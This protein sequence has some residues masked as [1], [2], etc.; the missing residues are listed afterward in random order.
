[1]NSIQIPTTTLTILS[2]QL[3]GQLHFDPL[4]RVLYATDASVYRALPQAV[5]LP[6]T[7]ED[8]QLLIRFAKQHG[9]SLLPRAA[10]TSLA[11]QCVGEGIVVDISKHFTKIIELNAEERWV[12]VQPGVVRDELNAF[13]QPHGLFFS[14]ITEA[15]MVRA[16]MGQLDNPMIMVSRG[17]ARRSKLP[18]PNTT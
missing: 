18:R 1:M 17:T 3:T 14:P 11:G 16:N 9:T 5:A 2:E 6:A 7:V 4:Q 10:G 12:R 13:L 15:L 8:L